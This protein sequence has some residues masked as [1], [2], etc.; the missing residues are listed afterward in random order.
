MA[1]F[2]L[3][4]NTLNGFVT[5]YTILRHCK[6]IIEFLFDGHTWFKIGLSVGPVGRFAAHLAVG[7]HGMI[8]MF[9][10]KSLE[11]AAMGETML[12]S[13]FVDANKTS[14]GKAKCT[15]ALSAAGAPGGDNMDRRTMLTS[16]SSRSKLGEVKQMS[17]LIA[18][19]CYLYVLYTTQLPA[20]KL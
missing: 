6:N 7:W 9:R 3:A 15:N 11:E 12:I 16:V 8:V 19:E 18:N 1:S 5:G 4:E 2:L 17:M 14:V 20:P 13:N 10:C